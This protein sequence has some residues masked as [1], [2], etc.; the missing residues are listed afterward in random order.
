MGLTHHPKHNEGGLL[1]R[2]VQNLDGSNIKTYF[3]LRKEADLPVATTAKQ[4]ESQILQFMKNTDHIH[5]NLD[6]VVSNLN[7]A[8]INRAAEFGAEGSMIVPRNVTRWELSQVLSK[9]SDKTTF[10]FEGQKIDL[11]KI[12]E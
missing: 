5:F 9:F 2:F 3:E 12:P 8:S 4:L 11:S 10:Y 6:G 1:D 7:K